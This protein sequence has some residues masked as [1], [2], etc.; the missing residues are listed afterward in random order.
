MHKRKIAIAVCFILLLFLLVQTVYA[1]NVFSKIDVLF[2]KIN[3]YVNGQKVEADNILYN[4]T[5]YVP[6]RKIS[7]MLGK[8]VTW[9][10]ATSSVDIIDRAFQSVGN[11]QTLT[12]DGTVYIGEIKDNFPSGY[13]MMLFRNGDRYIGKTEKEGPGNC[14]IY[15][16]ANEDYIYLVKQSEDKKI[17]E[18]VF[19]D[20]KD[21]MY[22][23]R[24]ENGKKNG[25]GILRFE[26]ATFIGE[27]TDN[28]PNGLFIW[29]GSDNRKYIGEMENG[30]MKGLGI[31]YASDGTKFVGEVNNSEQVYGIFYNQSGKPT[32][33]NKKK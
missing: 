18:G 28:N 7:E 2:N 17:S 3:L 32:L 1:Q 23:G 12:A 29:I 24:K 5:T 6:L 9:D 33:I 14:G 31:I 25:L 13:G 10:E 15:T 20:S 21:T 27:W 30:I 4:G 16:N 22:I 19:C 11:I 26:E 8:D